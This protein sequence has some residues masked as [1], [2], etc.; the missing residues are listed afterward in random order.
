MSS[1][2]DSQAT[3][4]DIFARAKNLRVIAMAVSVEQREPSREEW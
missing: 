1:M 2:S 4:S 3:G